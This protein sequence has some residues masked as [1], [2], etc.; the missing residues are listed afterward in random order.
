[1]TDRRS[2]LVSTSAAAVASM[3]LPRGLMTS[4]TQGSD[5]IKNLI[6]VNALGGLGG[7]DAPPPRG[8]PAVMSAGAMAAG[9]SSGLTAINMTLAGGDDFETTVQAI[10]AY[11][12]FLHANSDKLLKVDSTA[13]ILD[14]KKQGKIGV[15]YGFQNAAMMGDKAARVDIFADLGVRCIQLTYNS[16]NQLGGGSMD[17]ANTG[18]TAFGR[19]VV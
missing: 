4:T 8:P 19:E 10:A 18:L 16:L 6:V 3:R 1:M 17:P 14:A 9:K 7:G 11:D 2:F 5:P 13:D 15:I 12:A